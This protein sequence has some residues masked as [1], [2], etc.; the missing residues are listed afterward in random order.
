[1][2]KKPKKNVT[3][4]DKKT[5]HVIKIVLTHYTLST[6]RELQSQVSVL[7]IYN[8]PKKLHL[9]LKSESENASSVTNTK[10]STKS[11]VLKMLQN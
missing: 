6:F 5:N 4:E 8:G 1:M 11:E 9:T 10:H 3:R 7:W 2:S